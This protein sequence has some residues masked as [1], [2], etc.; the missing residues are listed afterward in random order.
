MVKVNDYLNIPDVMVPSYQ[1]L[2]AEILQEANELQPWHPEEYSQHS[3]AIHEASHCVVVAREG[4]KLKTARIFQ[5]SGNWLGDFFIDWPEATMRHEL[6]SPEFLAH[7]RIIL[8]GRRGELLFLGK[9]FCLR[10][11]LDEL[12]YALMMMLPALTARAGGQQAALELYGPAWETLL[13]EVD[14]TLLTHRR[15]V[16]AIADKLMLKGALKS[17]KLS[18]LVAPVLPR[19]NPPCLRAQDEL[20]VAYDPLAYHASDPRRAQSQWSQSPIGGMRQ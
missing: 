9:K 11:G 13:A 10:A 18:Q 1:G 17:R 5:A 2:L 19:S 14:D 4:Y 15:S 12:A 16:T 3:A 6:G 8:A 7:L 20:N